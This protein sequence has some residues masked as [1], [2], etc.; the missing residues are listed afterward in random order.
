MGSTAFD[1]ILLPVLLATIG[2]LA[3]CWLF[4]MLAELAGQVVNY[5]FRHQEEA[6]DPQDL[7]QE[8]RGLDWR[9]YDDMDSRDEAS[10]SEVAPSYRRRHAG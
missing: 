9:R 2:A 1:M 5:L 6:T 10:F 8:T 4:S 7:G 3:A